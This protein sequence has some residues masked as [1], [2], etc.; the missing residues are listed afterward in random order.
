[1]RT[2]QLKLNH[3]YE[4]SKGNAPD[5]MTSK[6]EKSNNIHV[7]PTRNSMSVFNIPSHNMCYLTTTTIHRAYIQRTLSDTILMEHYSLTLYFA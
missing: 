6:F 7:R 1:M 5:Y 3:M 2:E 4:I